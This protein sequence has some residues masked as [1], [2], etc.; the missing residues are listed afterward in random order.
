MSAPGGYYKM[1]RGWMNHPALSGARE[2]FCRRAAWAWLVEAASWKPRRVNIAGRTIELQRGQLTAS[3]RYLAEAWGWSVGAVRRFIERI[4]TDTL[5]STDTGTGQL[6]I[7]VCNYEKYQS[8]DDETGT[9]DGTP[10]GTEAAQLE[11]KTNKG[12]KGSKNLGDRDLFGDGKGEPAADDGFERWW[13]LAPRR[14]GKGQARVAFKSALGK[15]SLDVLIA[16][17]T[18]YAAS[19]Q[20]REPQ[21]VCHPSTWLRGERWLDESP[22]DTTGPTGGT[23]F[24]REWAAAQA[25]GPETI[26]AFLIKHRGK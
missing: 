16:G 19:V 8:Y 24:D 11:H 4:E 2:S 18:Q 17:I 12:K 7:T 21:F 1:H 25:A 22:D 13:A 9:A 15:A 10:S 6:V 20:G 5:V 23:D 26:E 14:I 3:L